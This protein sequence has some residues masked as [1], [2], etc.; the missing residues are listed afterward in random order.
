ML[1]IFITTLPKLTSLVNYFF[2]KICV[3]LILALITYSEA[4][5]TANDMLNAL[6][7]SQTTDVDEIIRR[8]F[9][10]S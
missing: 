8:N 6:A 9:L 3:K 7:L 4:V 5:F 2:W 1:I 10:D